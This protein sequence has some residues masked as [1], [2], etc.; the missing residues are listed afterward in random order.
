MKKIGFLSFGHWQRSPHSRTR[1]A[2]E[3]HLQTVE[4]ASLAES[5]RVTVT[6]QTYELGAIREAMED[7]RKGRIRGR[8]VLVP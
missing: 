8:A 2:Q 1:T 5:G 3:A 4:L 7:L 6:T